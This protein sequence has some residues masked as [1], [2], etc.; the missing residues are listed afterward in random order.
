MYSA[1][2]THSP[3]PLPSR[4]PGIVQKATLPISSRDDDSKELRGTSENR[5]HQT[6]PCALIGHQSLCDP[7]ARATSDLS[8]WIRLARTTNLPVQKLLNGARPEQIAASSRETKQSVPQPSTLDRF[9]KLRKEALAA[10]GNP[11]DNLAKLYARETFDTRSL[12][13]ELTAVLAFPANGSA[14]D[15][16]F[17][18]LELMQRLGAS[19]LDAD[20][21]ASQFKAVLKFPQA[22]FPED[23]K[24]ALLA[25][26]LAAGHAH[27]SADLVL[28]LRDAIFSTPHAQL[29]RVTKST[30]MSSVAVAGRS[31]LSPILGNLSDS[32][33]AL[34]NFESTDAEM[35]AL[36]SDSRAKIGV[37]AAFLKA[38]M[39]GNIY[40]LCSD[41]A[42]IETL[43]SESRKILDLPA[44][45][46]T[47][48]NQIHLMFS[49]HAADT[50]PF[51][52][53]Q[54]AERAATIVALAPDKFSDLEKDRLINFLFRHEHVIDA[55]AKILELPQHV[56]NR[57]LLPLLLVSLF[58]N[59]CK[60]MT[61]SAEV[62]AAASHIIRLTINQSRP[63]SILLL[64]CLGNAVTHLMP[65]FTLSYNGAELGPFPQS[66]TKSKDGKS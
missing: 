36:S 55:C 62:T 32:I 48:Q 30:L 26:L 6:S 59:H 4:D 28:R 54:L 45:Q 22:D 42:S 15:K 35:A 64:N 3:F 12:Y 20:L 14:F 7:W 23:A 60:N 57:E 29:D 41:R 1:A 34:K 18:L 61:N 27:M 47:R 65:S 49:L 51:T 52:I 2:T 17:D 31:N 63:K 8:T 56:L 66:R 58:R 33:F 19:H 24:L 44:G 40:V 38:T 43:R 9:E 53:T 10:Q 37:G 46:W 39:L 21:I 50:K 16:K 25:A 5:P 11:F 13:Q